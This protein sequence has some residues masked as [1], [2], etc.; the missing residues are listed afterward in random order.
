MTERFRDKV[1]DVMESEDIDTLSHISFSALSRVYGFGVTLRNACYR[2]GILK[3]SG[4][5][6]K[7]VSVGNITVGGSGKTPVVI[8]LAQRFLRKGLKV[9]IL[10]RGYKREGTGIEV[11]SDGTN[12]LLT[13]KHSGDEPYLMAK[14]LPGV[15]VIVGADRVASGALAVARFAPDVIL[16]DDGFQHIRL[17]RDLD[18]VLFD[19]ARGIGNGYLLPRG[20]LR[21]PVSGLS[22]ADLFLLKGDGAFTVSS[23]LEKGEGA[24]DVDVKSF[25]F[26]YRPTGLVDIN[27]ARVGLEKIKGKKV[28]ALAGSAGP[29]G[30]VK[31]IE[32]C[33]AKVVKELFFPDHQ[34]YGEREVSRIKENDVGVDLV[35]TTEKDLVRLTG[36]SV[37]G[38]NIQALIVD[39]SMQ[40]EAEFFDCVCKKLGI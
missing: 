20:P 31:T 27:G 22:R 21:E 9:A 16:L 2:S 1:E 19:A 28:L 7:V 33:G 40:Q 24:G 12:I 35:V 11:V 26:I 8:F 4:L 30:F 36:E 34:W 39:V 29:D 15:P 23:L 6:C 10:S 18:I 38:L 37:K 25:K 5:P 3:S 32:Q 13:P 17:G 14:R